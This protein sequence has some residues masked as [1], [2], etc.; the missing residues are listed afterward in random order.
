MRWLIGKLLTRVVV[1]YAAVVTVANAIDVGAKAPPFRLQ[2]AQG[3]TIALESLRGR[4]VYI[5]FWA[6]WCAPCRRSFPWMGE[7][8]LRYGQRGL[9][10]LA[11]NV[12]RQ[13]EAAERFLAAVPAPFTVAFD[14]QGATPDAYAATAM[15]SSYLV[16]ARGHVALVEVG[17]REERKAALEER[18]RALLDAR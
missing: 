9:T 12:D 11:I 7:M 13:R 17:F 6:S 4:V 2:D 8:Q 14:P 16:D 1:A 18:I 10:V 3:A 5:D 15:P